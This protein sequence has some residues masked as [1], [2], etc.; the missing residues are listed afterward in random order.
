LLPLVLL[1]LGALVGEM[2][3]VGEQVA[4]HQ[5][6]KQLLHSNAQVVLGVLVVIMAAVPGPMEL[7]QVQLLELLL[8]VLLLLLL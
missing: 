6:R 1:V 5:A 7:P 8:P 2:A 3:L 4:L